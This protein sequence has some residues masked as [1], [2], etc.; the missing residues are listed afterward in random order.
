[1]NAETKIRTVDELREIRE[2]LHDEGKVVVQCHGCFD[3][4]HPGHLRYLRFAREQGDILMVS[5]TSDDA[6][7]KGP[8]RPYI[9]ED[10]R[11]ENLA[12]IEYVDYVC[13]DPN[14]W[15]GPVL[16]ALQP[17]IYVKGKEYEESSDPRFARERELV[18][19][20]GGKVIFSSGEVVYSSTFILSQFRERFRLEEERARSF[21]RRYALDRGTLDTVLEGARGK[22]VLVLGDA[23]LDRY[24]HCEALS[25]AAESPIL[26][27]MPLHEDLYLGAG[28]LIAGQVAAL[29]GE[30]TFM[31]A[32]A[33]S[34]D[35][36][37]FPE[38]LERIGVDFIA[39]EVDRRPVYVKTRYLIDETKAFKVNQGGYSP[40]STT[41]GRQL[42]DR[43]EEM[44]SEFDAVLATDFGYGL[45][46]GG[47]AGEISELALKSERPLY[48]DVSQS[49]RTH[50]LEF[51]QP[52]LTAPTEEELRQ[53]FADSESGLSHLAA[54]FYRETGAGRLILTLGKRGTVLFEP[55]EKPGARLSSDYLPALTRRPID[56]VGAGDVFLATATLADLAGGTPA[57]A[58]YLANSVASL[59]IGSLGNE[60]VD[61]QDLIGFLD[62]RPELG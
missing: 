4:V 50:L 17:D 9:G 25:I 6:V 38:G 42:I 23:I 39:V 61:L 31:T 59:H 51:R 40:L 3:I 28:A 49:P 56:T 60:P 14:H 26:S 27:V 46:A 52:R 12:A 41:A 1:V 7:G 62:E 15:A 43:L 2:R 54:R 37:H 45:F 18:E 58:A 33:P 5:V 20:Y 48:V 53:A 30:A 21:A 13:L 34:P 16:E 29:G 11:L 47:L 10:L 57:C 36:E 24:I 8:D 55:P 35:L 19:S 44:I 32:A 22:R